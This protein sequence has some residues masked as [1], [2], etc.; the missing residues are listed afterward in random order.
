MRALAREIEAL[1]VRA[2]SLRSESAASSG[3][4]SLSLGDLSLEGRIDGLSPDQRLVERFTK[5]EGRVELTTWIEH[6]LAQAA[7]GTRR[8]SHLVL[9]GTN[10]RATLVSFS[11]VEDPA[12]LL[13]E[14]VGVYRNCLEVPLPL[15]GKA[16]RI[17]ANRFAEDASEDALKAARTELKRLLKHDLYLAYLFGSDDPFQ[18]EDWTDTFQEAAL[19]VYGA[20]FEHWSES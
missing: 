12:H 5:T 3:L 7:T 13:D 19:A 18:D 17:F 14:L 8:T 6:L 4:L 10:T 1:N 11:P 20:F 9:R 16:S 2:S 15:L